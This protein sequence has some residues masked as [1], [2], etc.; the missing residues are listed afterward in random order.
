MIDNHTQQ[1]PEPRLGRS[2]PPRPAG[3]AR[4]L[5]PPRDLG[6]PT[7]TCEPKISEAARRSTG[8]RWAL[9]AESGGIG[10]RQQRLE[11]T[12]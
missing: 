5:S 9:L 10:K 8:A 3:V 1:Q 11:A 4:Y 7:A 6:I 2:S 12:P